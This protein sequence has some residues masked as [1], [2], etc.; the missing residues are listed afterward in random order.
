MLSGVLAFGPDDLVH[1]DTIV[2]CR[3]WPESRA[4]PV[5]GPLAF[6]PACDF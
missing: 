6:G 4:K 3:P 1:S 2:M 5:L